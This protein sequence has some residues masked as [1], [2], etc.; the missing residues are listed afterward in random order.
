MSSA[1]CIVR[2]GCIPKFADVN[3]NTQNID[4]SNILNSINKKTKA[5]ICVHLAGLPVICMK[6]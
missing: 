1:S 5:I 2:N 4:P 6:F 3:I